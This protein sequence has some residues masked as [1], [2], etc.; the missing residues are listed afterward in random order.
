MSNLTKNSSVKWTKQGDREKC[1]PSTDRCVGWRL[2]RAKNNRNN[3]P[4]ELAIGCFWLSAARASVRSG[5][6]LDARP[7]RPN[8][9]PN[10]SNDP[11][12]SKN[13]TKMFQFLGPL[14]VV[15]RNEKWFGRWTPHSKLQPIVIGSHTVIQPINLKNNACRTNTCSILEQHQLTRKYL[16][17]G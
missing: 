6:C 8:F 16:T 13:H 11:K 5:C 15:K 17:S 10:S 1:D 4:S 9:L 12:T 3:R 7:R 14:F 2:P